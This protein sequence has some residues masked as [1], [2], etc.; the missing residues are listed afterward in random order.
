MA[1][2]AQIADSRASQNAFEGEALAGCC[3]CG[4]ERPPVR[5]RQ[6]WVQ[7]WHRISWVWVCR[8]CYGQY[9]D[10]SLRFVV[11]RAIDVAKASAQPR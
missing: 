8:Q 7:G 10:Y 1:E 5:T 2:K 6:L 11:S 9:P 3:L 4:R